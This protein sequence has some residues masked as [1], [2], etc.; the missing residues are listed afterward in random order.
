MKYRVLG[1]TGIRVSEIGFGAWGIGGCT[2][3]DT[4]Y[5]E[6]DDCVSRD[7]LARAF[8]VGINFFDTSNV[9]G[10]SEHLIGDTFRDRRDRVV[11]ATKAGFTAYDRPPD[12]SP[13]H[14]RR[15]LEE[16]LRSLHSDYV[17]LLQLHNPTLDVL[18]ED[19]G[20]LQTLEA[21]QREG[22]I[23]AYG[24]SFKSPE[25]CVTG[26]RE[27]AIPVVQAN[28]SMMDLRALDC[29]LLDVAVQHQ[30][31]VIARTPLCFGFLSGKVGED[32]S[33]SEGDHRRRWSQEQRNRWAEGARRLF[34]AVSIP[35]DQTHTQVALRF[36]LSFPAVATVIPG[37]LTPEEASENAAAGDYGPLLADQVG[38]VIEINR[39]MDFVVKRPL[40]LDQPGGHKPDVRKSN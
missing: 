10:R 2:P 23:R 16:S 25:E 18:G 28:L 21:L 4:S 8:D 38:H 27:H 22:K 15:S 37:I 20:A 17:D 24:M 14:I 31:A 9:Y 35:V 11:I 5:G 26:I 33:F 12:Y 39:S 36:C 13:A 7:A 30:A 32:T 29:G 1:R 34:D 6:T 19:R 3:G 40:P